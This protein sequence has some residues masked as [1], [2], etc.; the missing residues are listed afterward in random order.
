MEVILNV[1]MD[2]RRGRYAWAYGAGD[3]LMELVLQFGYGMMAHSRA[4]LAD[5]GGGAVILSPRDLSPDQLQRLSADVRRLAGRPLLDPQFY[6]PHADHERLR[7]HAFWSGEFEPD[8]QLLPA[9]WARLLGDLS[10]LNT[11]LGCSG[12]VL[13]G[14]LAATPDRLDI[15]LDQHDTLLTEAQREGILD[16]WSCLATI[17]LGADVGLHADSCQR[18]IEW[19]ER[20][21]VPEVY[22]VLEHPGGLYISDNPSW[23]C[24][25]LDLVGGLALQG[26]RVTVGYGNQQMLFT[27]CAG[28]A[29]LASGTWL[30]VRSFQPEKFRQV[31]DDEMRQRKT[32]YYAPA[33]LSEYGV[34]YLD[35]AARQGMLD[36]MRPLPAQQNRFSAA[37]FAAPQPSIGTF[38]EADAFLH[39]LWSLR[40]QAAALA[41]PTFDDALDA[42]RGLLDVAEERVAALAQREIRAQ[43]REFGGDAVL[44]CRAAL[45]SLEAGLGPRLRRQ[46]G[47]LVD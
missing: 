28:A 11:A 6:L 30:N 47:S 5:W 32:W 39:Y 2:T 34:P 36:L 31:Y 15:W 4:L 14:I 41:S 18:V 16:R 10:D 38:T 12:F 7:S 42:A 25:A 27:A 33:T 35:M 29:A 22:L 37:L 44:A 26:K 1:G 9:E 3:R 23:L 46:W 40:E 24:N 20:W 21:D 45:A 19:L 17:A 8:H 13:P 43:R